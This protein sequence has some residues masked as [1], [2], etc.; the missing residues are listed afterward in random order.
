MQSGNLTGTGDDRPLFTKV[1]I[2]SAKYTDFIFGTNTN[3]GYSYNFTAQ[4]Q[5]DDF[6]GLSAFLAYTYGHTMSMNDGISSQN[7]SQW[8]IPNVRGKNDIDLAISDF[9]LGSRVMAF[10]SY[11]VEYAKFLGTTIGLYY[12]GQSGQRYADGLY[13][14]DAPQTQLSLFVSIKVMQTVDISASWMY[15]DRYYADFNPAARTKPDD[16]K[17]PYRIPSYQSIDLHLECPFRVGTLKARADVGCLNALNSKYIIRGQD[18]DSH[19]INDFSG[20]WG[21]GRTF[22]L[23]LK[24]E[25]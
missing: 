18:G 25:F 2:E 23:S 17:Q 16:R 10:L 4:L 22:Y 7:S 24:L 13:V 11:K 14:G 1:N 3:K 12:N 6:H 15:Y 5:K 20:F 9:D 8:R 21:F 19:T